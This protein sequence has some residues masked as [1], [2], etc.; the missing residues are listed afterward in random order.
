MRRRISDPLARVRNERAAQEHA[1]LRRRIRPR[2]AGDAL[3][4][5][6]GN[7][8]LGLARDPRVVA[9]ATDAVQKWG[10]GS[11]G[12][13]LVT[14][15]T[16]L[17]ADLEQ[18]LTTH[19]GGDAALVFSS[20][21]LAN[22]GA[23]TALAGQDT[24][25]VSDAHNHASVIDACRLARARVVVVPHGDV[26]AVESAL[27]GRAESA[28]LLVT[29]AV[30][31]VDGDLAPVAELHAVARR[32][33]AL[34]LVDEAHALGV[35]GPRGEG[36][37]AT[38]GLADEPDVV[39]TVTLSK[40]L[41]SQGGAVL[42]N[43]EVIEHLVSTARTFIFDTALS[44]A[45]AGSALASLQIL[46]AEPA[47]AG[48]V[49]ANASRLI[50]SVGGSAPAA[51]IVSVPVGS[52]AEAVAAAERCADHGVRVGCFRP[53]SVPDGVSRIRLTARADLCDS[54]F[55]RFAAAWTG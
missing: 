43:S 20:G 1:G 2:A 54:D 38:T 5:L 50:E 7:D 45:C 41:G 34:L 17:H 53:P 26:Q 44:P 15:S 12:S 32:Y 52:P 37:V 28:A 51:A 8:Y 18:A 46:M 47:L 48:R 49:R 40:S 24:L 31:S 23:I 16:Q 30:F 19:C 21:Y 42:A 6:A 39:R 3:V 33:G 22:I 4:D 55:E 25:V 35:V 27:S 14:G 10:V 11:T 29:D 36:V 13:R 9:A